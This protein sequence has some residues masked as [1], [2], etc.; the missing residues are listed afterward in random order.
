M[1]GYNS[2][3]SGW[4]GVMEQRT[5]LDIRKLHRYR[6]LDHLGAAG[7]WQ[8]SA[9]GEVTATVDYR[10]YADSIGLE[11]KVTDDNGSEHV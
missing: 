7:T 2:G 4:R 10:V 3:R 9:E 5:R 6:I 8:W 1:G 11:Y